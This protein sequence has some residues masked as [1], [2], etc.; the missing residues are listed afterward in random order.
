MT[1]SRTSPYSRIL[2]PQPPE[3]R[4]DARYGHA[5]PAALDARNQSLATSMHRLRGAAPAAYRPRPPRSMR[6]AQMASHLRPPAPPSAA[7]AAEDAGGGA[8]SEPPLAPS[9]SAL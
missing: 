5:S 4:R 1:S 2:P 6:L 7:A 3:A 9:L 8:P